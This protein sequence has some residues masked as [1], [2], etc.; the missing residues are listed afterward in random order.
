MMENLKMEIF[1]QMEMERKIAERNEKA[2]N[3]SKQVEKEKNKAKLALSI[4]G[5]AIATL[6]VFYMMLFIIAIA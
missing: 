6:P 5:G 4:I 2:R 1:E 3:Y